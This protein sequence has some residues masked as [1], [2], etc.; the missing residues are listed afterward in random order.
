MPLTI[1]TIAV[2]P[3][4]TSTPSLL[5]STTSLLSSPLTTTTSSCNAQLY[6]IPT[7]DAACAVP[8]NDPSKNYTVPMTHCCGSASVT[9]YDGDC[10]LYCLAEGQDVG[11]LVSCLAGAGVGWSDVFCNTNMTARA[12]G[13]SDGGF[14]VNAKETGKVVNGGVARRD[15]GWRRQMVGLVG[16]LGLVVFGVVG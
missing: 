7:T 10:G 13:T 16:V 8:N 4:S 9:S 5:A 14:R 15:T 3:A 1:T 11:T 12:T 6:T 2:V